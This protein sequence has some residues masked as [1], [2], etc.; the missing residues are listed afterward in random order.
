MRFRG[1]T[2][3]SDAVI[4]RQGLRHIVALLAVGLLLAGTSWGNPPGNLLDAGLFRSFILDADHRDPLVAFGEVRHQVDASLSRE[5]RANLGG[6]I[7]LME[8]IR[9]E[10]ASDTPRWRLVQA[11]TR[12]MIVPEQRPVYAALF[13]KYCQAAVDFVLART[14]L[15]NPY[16]DIATFEGENGQGSAP[17]AGGGVTAYLVHH[18]AD[19]YT[20][21]YVFF[22]A[23]DS[24]PQVKIELSNRNYTGEVGS[25]SSYLV[26]D[27]DQNLEFIHSPYTLWRNSAEHPL[28]VLIAPVEETLHIALRHFTEA[29]IERRLGSLSDRS[30]PY[31]DQV[32]EEWL[33]VEE[34]AVGGLVHQLMPE[35]MSRFFKGWPQADLDATFEARRSFDKYRYLDQGVRIVEALGIEAFIDR[36]RRDPMDFRAMLAPPSPVEVSTETTVTSE[37]AP[38]DP[39]A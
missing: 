35:V 10:L 3:Y 30:R 31:I 22:T 9:S 17:A 19:V 23:K 14:R 20:E 27:E 26:I 1:S 36:Y 37:P 4:R 13:E 38:P 24:G 25:Y 18:I 6:N 11:S 29:A 5:N 21:E 34:A 8:S 12:L 15:P 7:T 32:V 2:P 16:Q 28:N 33:A 39:S